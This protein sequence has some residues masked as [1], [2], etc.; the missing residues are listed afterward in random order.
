M[1]PDSLFLRIVQGS[2]LLASETK[3]CA[4]K[5]LPIICNEI[6]CARCRRVSIL[7]RSYSCG[8]CLCLECSPLSN[9]ICVCCKDFIQDSVMLVSPVDRLLSALNAAIQ[10]PHNKSCRA[11]YS[12]SAYLMHL[13]TAHYS[14]AYL[15]DSSSQKTATAI[16]PLENGRPG[17]EMILVDSQSPQAVES[18]IELLCTTPSTENLM[19]DSKALYQ[20]QIGDSVFT[21]TPEAL[22]ND[23]ARIEEAITKCSVFSRKEYQFIVEKTSKAYTSDGVQQGKALNF[24]IQQLFRW[25]IYHLA[26]LPNELQK[27]RS[28]RHLLLLTTHP[29]SHI[30]S[31]TLFVRCLL[32]KALSLITKLSI[33]LYRQSY[34]S[35]IKPYTCVSY[36][37]LV[38][39][40]TSTL[41][42]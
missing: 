23:F 26:E 28:A 5:S 33:S 22:Q 16:A 20:L 21:G 35:R 37:Y 3:G 4:L 6:V 29:S 8:H 17:H 42:C 13:H 1:V 19:D 2:V 31:S 10:C 15:A 27:P 24:N 7:V 12:L 39:I 38:A 25:H 41:I 34:S 18:V 32:S 40:L 36:I 30:F 9:L 11:Y 14:R